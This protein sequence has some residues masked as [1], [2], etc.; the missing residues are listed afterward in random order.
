[1]D[2]HKAK[3]TDYLTESLKLM[4]AIATI[5]FGGLLAYRSNLPS[6]VGINQFYASLG[7]LALSS[8]LSVANI[9]SLINKMHSG[10][11]DAIKKGDVKTLN[12]LSIA[13]LVVGIGYGALFLLDQATADADNAIAGGTVI[14]D[15]EIVV[16]NGMKAGIT[17]VK[18]DGKISEVVISPE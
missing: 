7:F 18:E 14:S 10:D 3:A 4:V 15:S 12:V 16:G 17:V 13:T 11:G 5:L 2:L 8:C 9:N 1:M 6:P